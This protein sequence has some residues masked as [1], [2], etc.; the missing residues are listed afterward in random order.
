MTYTNTTWTTLTVTQVKGFMVVYRRHNGQQA[1]AEAPAVL[2]QHDPATGTR[3]EVF[4][5]VDKA[6]GELVPAPDVPGYIATIAREDWRNNVVLNM[7]R[8]FTPT[9]DEL[10]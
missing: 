7:G 6:T 1:G 4:A 9:L 10:A 5:C 8:D 3:R 2:V